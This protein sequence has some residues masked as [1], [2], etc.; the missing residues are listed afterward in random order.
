MS[1]VVATVLLRVEIVQEDDP[2]NPALG[3]K[4]ESWLAV[5]SASV[6]QSSFKP[7][8]RRW[9]YNDAF[10]AGADPDER[11]VAALHALGREEA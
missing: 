6:V 1:D 3:E 9:I 10:A 11:M 7:G 2:G 8:I 5:G 4:A